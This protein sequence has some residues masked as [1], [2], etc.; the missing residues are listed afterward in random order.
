MDLYQY[1]AMDQQGQT[2]KG[3]LK[4]DTPK[5]VRSMLRQQGLVPVEVVAIQ[6]KSKDKDKNRSVSGI[7]KRIKLSDLAVIT[8]ELGALLKAGLELEESL[9]STAQNCENK[10][11]KNILLAIHAKIVEG[12]SFSNGLAQYPK[13]FPHVYRASV[14]AGEE[15]GFVGD[16]LMNLADYLDAQQQMRQKILTILLYPAILTFVA[17][18]IVIFLLVYVAPKILTIFEQTQADL[19]V[20]TK[21]LIVVSDFLA[22]QGLILL[23]VVIAMVILWK[24]LLRSTAFVTKY[25]LLLLKLPVLGRLILLIQTG[26][27]LR[28]LSILTRANVPILKGVSVSSELISILPIKTQVQKAR[29]YIKEGASIH[30]SLQQTTY[31]SPTTLQFVASGE[32]TGDLEKMLLHAATNQE[33]HIQFTMDTF[34]ALFEPVLILLMGC[35]VLFIVLAMLLPMFQISTMI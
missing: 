22:Q 13:A 17:M 29:D 10:K 33:R 11:L 27:F 15:A 31:F 30:R 26:R 28:T 16:V 4:G 19:P 1:T 23:G 14:G 5:M 21:I 25:H 12:F 7:D 34:L 9:Y 18:G 24:L 6:G 35:I 3:T 20:V 2:Q 32:A 8:R